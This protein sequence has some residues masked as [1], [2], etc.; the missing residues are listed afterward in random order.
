MNYF[1]KIQI[2]IGY[3]YLYV[4]ATKDNDRCQCSKLNRQLFLSPLEEYC[5]VNNVKFNMTSIKE[6]KLEKMVKINAGTYFIGTNNPVFV[7]DGEEPKREV[8]LDNFYIDKFEVSNDDFRAFVN[9]TGYITDAENFGESFVFENFLEQSTKDKINKAVAQAPW[10]LP[11]K[12]ASWQHPEGPNSNITFRMDHPVIHVSWHDAVAYCSWM[13]KRLPTEAEWEVACRGGLSDRLYPWGNKLVPNNQHKAN[14]WQ[15]KFPTKNTEEDGYKGTSPVTIFLQNKYG[16]HNMIGNVWEWTADWW[17]TKHSYN[18]QINPIGPSGGSN[19]V[20]K[21]GS[22]LCH[23]N[24]CYR[25]RCAARSQNTPDT[26]AGNL[27]FR[28]AVSA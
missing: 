23:K 27:G 15:G 2:I 11:V 4:I 9:A 24:Y 22:Y 21:G 6:K 25:Y 14:T 5:T 18:R 3:Y 8:I 16:L 28:C 1:Y 26:S 20:K 13:R 12:Q 19:K 17:T 7:A 10:W